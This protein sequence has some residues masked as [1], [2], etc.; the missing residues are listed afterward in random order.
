[1][2]D[3]NIKNPMDYVNGVDS[4]AK[5]MDTIKKEVSGADVAGAV[6][7]GA[8]NTQDFNN[9]VNNN[10]ITMDNIM[11]ASF[12]EV[13]NTMTVNFKKTV[14][15]RDYETEVIE[16][17]TTLTLDKKLTGIERM[18]IHALLEVQ[19]EYTV[20]I[21]LLCKGTVTQTAFNQHK[22]CLEMSVNVIKNKMDSLLGPERAAELIEYTKLDQK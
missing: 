19:M 3:I 11:D 13:S 2:T 21:N 14:L 17:T 4:I 10:V 8:V 9:E 1:M 7:V 18:F 5:P 20:Y 12:G 6:D 16:S 22:S 15:I